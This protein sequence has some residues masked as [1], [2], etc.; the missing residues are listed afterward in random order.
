M[1]N[2]FIILLTAVFVFASS[3]LLSK[4]AASR[5]R[6]IVPAPTATPA[7]D[8]ESL[9]DLSVKEIVI[10]CPPGYATRGNCPEDQLINVKTHGI[11]PLERKNIY[12]YK[13]TGGRVLGGGKDVRWDLTNT[14]PGTYQMTVSVSDGKN[15]REATET[16]TVRECDCGGDCFCP[17]ISVSGNQNTGNDEVISFTIDITGGTAA[18]DIT[19]NWTVSQGEIISGQ[20]T[21]AIAVKIDEKMKGEV[22]ASVEVGGLCAACL[23]T[24]SATVRITK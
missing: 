22:K 18:G 4:S 10:P 2:Y 17:T 12:K 23:K 7:N 14:R 3:G 8:S 5:H 20:G 9:L 21:A 16:I 13:V 11:N 6:T 15:T 19:R 1:R 24:A